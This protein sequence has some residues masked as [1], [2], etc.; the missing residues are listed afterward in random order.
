MR[1][2]LVV[3]ILLGFFAVQ[4]ASG[5]LLGYE[6][7]HGDS[8]PANRFNIILLGDAWMKEQMAEYRQVCK[9]LVQGLLTES[10]FFEYS[11]CFRILR[12]DVAS[13]DNQVSYEGEP[14]RDT[15]FGITIG[16]DPA[17][18]RPNG[19]LWFPREY[20]LRVQYLNRVDYVLNCV[21]T[22]KT[23]NL[24]VVVANTDHIAGTAVY[25]GIAVVTRNSRVQPQV[26]CHEVG[27]AMAQLEE[28][29]TGNSC[30]PS[31][32]PWQ[33]NATLDAGSN[34]FRPKWAHWMGTQGV[35]TFLG[36]MGCSY[37]VLRPANDCMMNTT[38]PNVVAASGIF[39][40]NI[41][42]FCAVCRE[43]IVQRLYDA[44]VPIESAVPSGSV[45]LRPFERAPTFKVTTVEGPRS[46]LAVVWRLTQ[47]GFFSNSYEYLSTTR[48]LKTAVGKT[49]ELA[50]P[51]S[52]SSGF[53]YRLE[54]FVSDET[55]LVRKWPV[56]YRST[57]ADY[58][59]YTKDWTIR[60]NNR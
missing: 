11:H 41:V 44:V 17:T 37:G 9:N 60:V 35:S 38:K 14:R 47:E 23:F 34:R 29:Y 51:F 21:P 16:V 57:P 6:V 12:L 18:A 28:E 15:A 25:N 36:G 10:P 26:F 49:Y 30:P 33:A 54:C 32:E 58:R 27:H 24:V 50:L 39:E 45:T 13:R 56:P 31:S 52:L 2:L 59:T 3:T 22:A 8:S 7:I 19:I 53:T 1:R 48:V 40:P 5:Q 4:P 46:E 43:R 20:S 55:P 42:P